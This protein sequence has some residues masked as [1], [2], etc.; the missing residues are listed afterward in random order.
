MNECVQ[1]NVCADNPSFLEAIVGKS[2]E[3]KNPGQPWLKT[4][5]ISQTESH[6]DDLLQGNKC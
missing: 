2:H 6:R 5:P 3:L 4:E 1:M